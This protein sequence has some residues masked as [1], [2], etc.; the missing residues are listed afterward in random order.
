MS[1]RKLLSLVALCLKLSQMLSYG[2]SLLIAYHKD[3]ISCIAC[4]YS[5]KSIYQTFAMH[6]DKWFWCYDTFRRKS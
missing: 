5:Y 6:L 1:E 2:S 3:L 4:K